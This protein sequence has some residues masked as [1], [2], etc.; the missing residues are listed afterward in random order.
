MTE[1][2]I[3]EAAR[4][5]LARNRSDSDA[6]REFSLL[7]SIGNDKFPDFL[8]RL[9]E[10]AIEEMD[11]EEGQEGG[12]GDGQEGGEVHDDTNVSAASTVDVVTT[13]LESARTPPS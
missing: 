2:E 7:A 8:L 13:T 1:E 4:Q 10:L 6:E 9:L 3:D 11:A 5:V 12:A